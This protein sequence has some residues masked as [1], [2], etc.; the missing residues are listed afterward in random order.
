MRG[1]ARWAGKPQGFNETP[2][3]GPNGNPGH[4]RRHRQAPADP[5]Q[6]QDHPLSCP[7]PVLDAVLISRDV[8]FAAAGV[9]TPTTPSSRR[10]WASSR[11]I[12][13]NRRPHSSV[14]QIRSLQKSAILWAWWLQT[15]QRKDKSMNRIVLPLLTLALSLAPVLCWA[16]EPK[17]EEAKTHRQAL[18]H[19]L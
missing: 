5:A 17:A 14:G 15:L 16:A 6:L 12:S 8:R 10:A 4:R 9:A 2:P 19:S 1:A 11:R 13:G 3:P 18:S 7:P